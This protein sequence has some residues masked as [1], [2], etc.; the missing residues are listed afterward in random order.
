MNEQHVLKEDSVAKHFKKRAKKYIFYE[1]ANLAIVI[2]I[3]IG[4]LF[5]V[6]SFPEEID[7]EKTNEVILLIVNKTVFLVLILFMIRVFLK[8]QEFNTR[9]AS[10]M[11]TIADAWAI[12]D[13]KDEFFKMVEVLLP[14]KY[15]SVKEFPDS[16]IESLFEK[17]KST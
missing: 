3:I 16:K 11:N 14:E 7:L 8:F 2:L 1:Y 10:L 15:E 9:R 13:N 6:R 4:G 12:S 17:I 5:L